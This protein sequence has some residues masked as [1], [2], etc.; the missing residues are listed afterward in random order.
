MIRYSFIQNTHTK[1][2]VTYKPLA[3]YYHYKLITTWVNE[4]M[5]ECM[6]LPVT[7]CLDW[8][9]FSQ[10]KIKKNWSCFTEY[11]FYLPTFNKQ[12]RR[13]INIWHLCLGRN[14]MPTEWLVTAHHVFWLIH[15]I[16]CWKCNYIFSDFSVNGQIWDSTIMTSDS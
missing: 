1:K 4:Q 2:H 11:C 6:N 15:L 5:D 3:A 16:V 13:I 9:G 10:L 14:K 7:C 8:W 12:C